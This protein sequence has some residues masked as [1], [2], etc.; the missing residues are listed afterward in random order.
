MGKTIRSFTNNPQPPGEPR[1]HSHTDTRC[2]VKIITAVAFISCLNMTVAEMLTSLLMVF[3]TDPLQVFSMQR[4]NI[5]LELFSAGVTVWSL[6]SWEFFTFSF[7]FLMPT[8]K[9]FGK[10]TRVLIFLR[11]SL[12]HVNY[13]KK[14]SDEF[15]TFSMR[16]REALE[17]VS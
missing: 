1:S 14:E 13:I 7:S 12:L 16:E 15:Y 17:S 11:R 2:Q 3:F 9:Y 5:A 10:P 6:E 4:I 8:S